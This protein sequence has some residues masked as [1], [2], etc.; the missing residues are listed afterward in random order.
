M[1]RRLAAPAVVV[2]ALAL[3][4]CVAV[5][6]VPDPTTLDEFATVLEGEGVVSTVSL[7]IGYDDERTLEVQLQDPGPVDLDALR[8]LTERVLTEAQAMVE[9]QGVEGTSVVVHLDTEGE[10]PLYVTLDDEVGL[11]HLP[12]MLDLAT[13]SP[14]HSLRVIED[15]PVERLL[16]V[17]C[18]LDLDAESIAGDYAAITAAAVDSPA[19]AS[20]SWRVLSAHGGDWSLVVDGGP[21]EGRGA[22][23]EQ[24]LTIADEHDVTGL[25]IQDQVDAILVTGV[26]PTATDAAC[27]DLFA[28]MDGATSLAYP[29]SVSLDVPGGDFGSACQRLS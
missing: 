14:C 9:E 7:E 19:I 28:T 27:D 6:P 21:V 4:A 8:D 3:S 17:E 23:L 22:M 29:P 24:V 2:A 1:S 11:E 16:S 10:A 20:T 18:V 12:A 25:Q 13:S 5:P 15:G 26:M